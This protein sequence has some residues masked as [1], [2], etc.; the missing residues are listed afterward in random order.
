MPILLKEELSAAGYKDDPERFREM[1]ADLKNAL[2]R[3]WTEEELSLHPADAHQ[4][5]NVVRYR[6]SLDMLPDS[7]ILRTL[8]NRR[9]RPTKGKE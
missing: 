4:F 1:L 2:Y 8:Y 5:C 9:K 6:T 7:L 3:N